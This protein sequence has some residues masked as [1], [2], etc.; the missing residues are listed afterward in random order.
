M[1]HGCL[2]FW[3]YRT[4]Q[5]FSYRKVQMFFSYLVFALKY[6]TDYDDKSFVLVYVRKFKCFYGFPNVKM[7]ITRAVSNTFYRA[8]LWK[9]NW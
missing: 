1:A 2:G 4:I 6:S 8:Q 7:I 9:K 5:F 3:H